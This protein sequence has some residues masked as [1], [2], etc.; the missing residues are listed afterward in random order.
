MRMV[1]EPCVGFIRPKQI[2]WL[3]GRP[4]RPQ[5]RRRLLQRLPRPLLLLLFN[6]AL[7]I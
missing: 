6:D 2:V 3:P 4:Q 1:M 7:R 5:R